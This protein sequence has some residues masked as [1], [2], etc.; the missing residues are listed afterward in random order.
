MSE[1]NKCDSQVY[2]AGRRGSTKRTEKVAK[3]EI[4]PCA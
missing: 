4:F 1:H 3:I 2:E